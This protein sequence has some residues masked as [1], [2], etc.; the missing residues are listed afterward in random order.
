METGFLSIYFFRLRCPSC[1]RLFDQKHPG[2][3]ELGKYI[4]DLLYYQG[5]L[6][7]GLYRFSGR[8][9]K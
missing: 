5:F 8:Y 4:F 2:F 6:C 9:R 7:Q 3:Y 1:R